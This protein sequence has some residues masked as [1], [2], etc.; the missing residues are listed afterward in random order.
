M[1]FKQ[2]KKWKIP[3]GDVLSV[4]DSKNN[5][6]WEAPLQWN[7]EDGSTLTVEYLVNFTVTV[8]NPNGEDFFITYPTWISYVGISTGTGKIVSSETTG[9]RDLDVGGVIGECMITFNPQR[10]GF[11]ILTNKDFILKG[12]DESVISSVTVTKQR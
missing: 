3:E 4:T 11:T 10:T 2:V 9:Y 12:P 6:L 1:D 7:L 8:I 5:I